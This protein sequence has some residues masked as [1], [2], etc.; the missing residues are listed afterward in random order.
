ME[1]RPG[2]RGEREGECVVVMESRSDKEREVLRARYG[3]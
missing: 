2:A 3:T 1:H